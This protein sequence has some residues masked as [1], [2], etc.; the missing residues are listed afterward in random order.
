MSK[1]IIKPLRSFPFPRME[2]R[3]P[4]PADSEEKSKVKRLAKA[5]DHKRVQAQRDLQAVQKLEGK[6]LVQRGP[7]KWGAARTPK[8]GP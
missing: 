1:E 7:F 6:K 5:V 3:N 2:I 8:A 4:P